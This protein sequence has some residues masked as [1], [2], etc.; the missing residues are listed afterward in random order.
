MQD[1]RTQWPS[2]QAHQRTLVRHVVLLPAASVA[3]SVRL[4]V[5]LR[6]VLCPGVFF[7]TGALLSASTN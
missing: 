4:T 3:E 6:I 5:A 7:S 1:L 2:H